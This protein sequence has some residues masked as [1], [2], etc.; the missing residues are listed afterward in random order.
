MTD[1]RNAALSALDYL[2]NGGRRHDRYR[3]IDDIIEALKQ[4]DKEHAKDCRTCGW[5]EKSKCTAPTTCINHDIYKST[6]L[7]QLWR[8][9]PRKVAQI[10]QPKADT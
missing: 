5:F 8:T 9:S 3:V 2:E 1:L 10:L 4:D 6:N 7:V